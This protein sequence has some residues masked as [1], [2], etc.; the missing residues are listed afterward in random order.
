MFLKGNKI[1][2]LLMFI[3]IMSLTACGSNE[4]AD[5][6]ENANNSETI[7]DIEY[8]LVKETRYDEDGTVGLWYEH[9]YDDQAM[10]EETYR[11]SANDTLETYTLDQYDANDLLLSS[12][13]YN[14]DG[15]IQSRD[16]YTY[17]DQ[18]R[19]LTSTH[20]EADETGSL[21]SYTIENV[22]DENSNVI[23]EIRHQDGTSCTW[24]NRMYNE[25]NQL[26]HETYFYD[27]GQVLSEADYQYDENGNIISSEVDYKPTA[28]ISGFSDRTE[29]AYDDSGNKLSEVSYTDG[30]M[31][32]STEYEYN[33]NGL[34]AKS[35]TVFYDIY[36][37]MEEDVFLWTYEYEEVATG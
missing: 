8:R 10:T 20:F 12:T 9:R 32:Y 14:A 23:E 37:G 24:K 2:T 33:E 27:S 3:L 25:K 17:D 21:S 22:Y 29:T 36:T 4:S 5:S 31:S 7:P 1:S 30:E 34:L 11:Y 26:I 35:T 15:E 6:A 28:F 19:E 16:E 13:T 18:K